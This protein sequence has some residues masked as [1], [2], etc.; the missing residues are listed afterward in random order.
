VE[1]GRIVVVTNG[2][3]FARVILEPL[4]R[5]RAADVAGVVIV[6]GIAAGKSRRQ[7]L[8]GIL[9]S[10]GVRHFAFKASTYL[11]F[12]VSSLVL[13][14]K[15]F[16]VHQ[17]AG[18][19]GIPICFTPYVNEPRVLAQVTEWRPGVLVSVSCPQ[20]IG[21]ELLAVPT[22]GAINVHSSLL[23]RYAGIEPYLWVL[24]NGETTTGTTVH[25]MREEFDTGDIIVQKELPIRAR[26]TVMSLFY[27]LSL[28]G[29]EALKEAVDAV[30]AGSTGF[31][32]QDESRR[33]YYSWPTA[34]TIAS[35]YR[36]GHR[37]ARVSD[38]RAPLA[39]A[40]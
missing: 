4:L 28:L 40:R 26:E 16:F 23:P 1:S 29:G 12:A 7:S 22:K 24:A 9:R 37:L 32:G 10:G 5:E 2:N 6:T 18:R 15:S 27:R 38:F 8:T 30:L 17:L 36:N 21:P 13:R 34:E 14:K 33:T 31:V 25:L 11:V 3:F 20:R 35:L 39:D 19:L